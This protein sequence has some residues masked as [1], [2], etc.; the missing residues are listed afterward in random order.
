[1]IMTCTCTSRLA[2]C[3]VLYATIQASLA[4][5]NSYT[6]S[7][8]LTSSSTTSASPKSLDDVQLDLEC[9]GSL[10]SATA[11]PHVSI[12][13]RVRTSQ[14]SLKGKL[15][16]MTR[17]GL[18]VHCQLVDGTCRAVSDLDIPCSPHV[19]FLMSLCT[20]LLLWIFQ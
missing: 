18:E 14:V 4:A 5:G 6:C 2:V 19:V 10:N 15:L 11:Q 16:M 17:F 1:M 12:D 8:S 13:E 20:H 7:L 9:S 3:A